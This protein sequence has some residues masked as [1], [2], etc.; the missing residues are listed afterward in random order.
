MKSA[1]KEWLEFAEKDLKAANLLIVDP[2]LNAT[3]CFHCQQCTEK[4]LKAIIESKGQNPPKSHD[5]IRLYGMIEDF[6]K[7]D[8]DKLARLNEVYIDARYP[9]GIGLLPGGEP[10]PEDVMLLLEYAKSVYDSVSTIL[11]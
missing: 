4:C 7:L 9:A 6:L 8:E 1:V 11:Q 10:T 3:A 2:A 5:L